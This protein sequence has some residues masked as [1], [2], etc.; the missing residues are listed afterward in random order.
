[1]PYWVEEIKCVNAC[2]APYA[3]KIF[4]LFISENPEIIEK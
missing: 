4:Y 3:Q 1:M 2:K